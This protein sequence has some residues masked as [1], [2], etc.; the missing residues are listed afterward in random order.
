M[1]LT[2]LG[3]KIILVTMVCKLD[4]FFHNNNNNNV[5]TPSVDTKSG[6]R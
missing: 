4:G 2:S 5:N 6:V 1:K 3:R